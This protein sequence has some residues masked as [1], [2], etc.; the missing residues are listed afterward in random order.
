MF[1]KTLH[2]ILSTRVWMMAREPFSNYYRVIQKNLY[3]RV[4]VA[5]MSFDKE[6]DYY[7]YLCKDGSRVIQPVGAEEFNEEGAENVNN[8]QEI[9]QSVLI[10]HVCG[11]V[12]RGGYLCTYGSIDH[13]DFLLSAAE[14]PTCSGVVF[15]I[16]TPGGSAFSMHDYRQGLDAMKAAGKRS[17]SFIDGICCSAGVALACQTDYI[18]VMNSNDEIGCIGAMIAGW[19]PIGG[20][21][22][23]GYRFID[24]TASQTPDKNLEFREAAQGEYKKLQQEVD[25]CGADFLSLIEEMRPQ[26]LPEQRTGKVYRA[27]A[28]IGTL[29]DGLSNLDDCVNYVLTGDIELAVVPSSTPTHVRTDEEENVDENETTDEKENSIHYTMN[30]KN[31]CAKLGLSEL[32]VQDGGVFLNEALVNQLDAAL[33]ETT[34][35]IPEDT[36]ET[37]DET[38]EVNTETPAET[39]D[40]TPAETTEETAEETTDETPAETTDETPAETTEETNEEVATGEQ[41]AQAHYA[42]Q[43]AA[44]QLQ[45]EQEMQNLREELDAA[46]AEI[47]NLSHTSDPAPAP[48]NRGTHKAKVEHQAKTYREMSLAEKRE[49]WNNL[50]K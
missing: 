9:E 18:T 24:V 7:M 44:M 29:V 8:E 22:E 35:D 42:R 3:D 25:I 36:A 11:P 26:I 16:D 10:L 48:L 21:E 15:V 28:V 40:D 33:A 14:D 47:E 17:I 38:S 2:E 43:L 32:A 4:H 37:T 20:I 30:T 27:G 6:Q 12:T 1:N 23:G 45:H 39:T 49:A 46:R 31:I 19:M 41:E 50:G 34:E 13:R 5:D